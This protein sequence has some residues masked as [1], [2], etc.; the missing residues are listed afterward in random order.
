MPTALVT[1]ASAG[2]GTEFA[3]QLA[4]D[5]YH[6]VLVARAKDRLD[7]IADELAA[8]HAIDAEALP[9]DLSTAEGRAAVAE[10]LTTG[11][12]DLLVNNAGFGIADPFPEAD[13]VELQRQ[14]DVNVTAVLQLT[15]AALP[16]MLAR[17]R[18]DVLNV[19]SVAGFLSGH[20]VTYSASKNWVVSFSE[21]LAGTVRGTGVRVMALCPGFTL[22]E[23]H[24][25]AGVRRTVPGFMWLSAARVVRGGLADLRRGKVISV[26][27]PHYKAMVALIGITPRPVLRAL[28]GRVSARERI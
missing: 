20:E 18:G 17:G 11:E 3:R 19:A 24:E 26:P 9:A 1:G 5:G 28:G 7:A 6:L 10:R 21:G 13:L 22:T 16:A 23:F 15:R 12:I 14:L 2:I 4:A 27:S 8:R 25:R